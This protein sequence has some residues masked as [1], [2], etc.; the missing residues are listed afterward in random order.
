M[1]NDYD[2]LFYRLTRQ[3]LPNTKELLGKKP[4]KQSG[5]H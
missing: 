4:R 2:A 5:L 3:A 1:D